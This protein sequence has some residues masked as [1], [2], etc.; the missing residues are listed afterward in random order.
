MSKQPGS[1]LLG[2]LSAVFVHAVDAD[3]SQ[4]Q[5]SLISENNGAY[6]CDGVPL[7]IARSCSTISQMGSEVYCNGTRIGQVFSD[8]AAPV[9]I[10]DPDLP[11]FETHEP[12]VPG[13]ITIDT[14]TLIREE[15]VIEPS[16]ETLSVGDKDVLDK[17]APL[18]S[19][20]TDCDVGAT[21][22][23]GIKA[24]VILRP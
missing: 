22:I 20:I 16:S 3:A 5:C 12:L 14:E 4:R 17:A 2:A 23:D 6:V 13:T 9:I 10:R 21:M 15:V 19:H 18:P 11:E 7:E 1:V 24:C 8:A